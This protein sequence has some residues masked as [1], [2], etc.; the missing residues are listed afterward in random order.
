MIKNKLTKVL[1]LFVI[2]FSCSAISASINIVTE[3]L[4]LFQIVKEDSITELSTIEAT[5]KE[6]N[7]AYN[8]DAH[9]W[10][11]SYNRALKEKTPVYTQ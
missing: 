6:A 2:F 9:P 3:H 4:A 5:L 11:L 7:I 8:I 10:S 1:M